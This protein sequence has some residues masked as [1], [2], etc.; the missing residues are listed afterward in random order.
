M[1]RAKDEFRGKKVSGMSPEEIDEF[2]DRGLCIY[3]AC[4]DENGHPHVAV[5]WQEW[6]DGVFWLVARKR[7]RWAEHLA[8]DRHVSFVVE[9]S[10]THEKV[11]GK[12]IAEV[13][14][15]PNIGGAWVEVAE[16]MS[17]RYLGEDGSKYLVPTI[18]QPRWLIRIT[19][20]E[21]QT[22]QG[23]GW[24]PRY[25]VGDTGG[26]SYE[27]AHGLVGSPRAGDCET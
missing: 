10:R 3:L 15:Q 16:R 7:A 18:Q 23:A 17:V 20:T 13:V 25:W 2:L 12:G 1:A 19:P 8:H 4:L 6:R 11:W 14:E 26:P 27:E 9:L 22:W 21:I 5:A 24:A